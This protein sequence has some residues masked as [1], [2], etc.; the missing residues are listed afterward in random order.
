MFLGS[1]G[2]ESN[3]APCLSLVQFQIEQG[4]LVMTAY[5]PVSYT[6]LDVYKRQLLYRPLFQIDH[7]QRLQGLPPLGQDWEG[8][9]PVSYTH[10]ASS[11]ALR[12]GWLSHLPLPPFCRTYRGASLSISINVCQFT[13]SRIC[14]LYTSQRLPSL[15]SYSFSAHRCCPSP[16]RTCPPAAHRLS[17][18]PS[19]R[20]RSPCG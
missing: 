10:L 4:E 14:L 12:S 11:S 1:T 3:Q 16:C 9:A 17:R 19:A 8:T 18:C 20:V 5:Q 7:F 2:T 13:P 6:H 15:I